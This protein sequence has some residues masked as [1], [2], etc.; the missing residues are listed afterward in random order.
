[1][2]SCINQQLQYQTRTLQSFQVLPNEHSLT[3]SRPVSSSAI[4]FLMMLDGIF[5]GE[6]Y[7]MVVTWYPPASWCNCISLIT[8]SSRWRHNYH[9]YHSN[10]SR[11]IV[12]SIDHTVMPQFSLCSKCSLKLDQ[13]FYVHECFNQKLNAVL[14]IAPESEKWKVSALKVNIYDV[15]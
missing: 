2:S 12:L 14:D 11:F 10:P 8:L 6:Y 1:M 9:F 7:G 4:R 5:V 13:P 3:F 15:A